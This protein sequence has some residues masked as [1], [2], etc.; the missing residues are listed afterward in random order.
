MAYLAWLLV[1]QRRYK[2]GLE[3]QIAQRTAEISAAQNQLKSTLDA[4][5]DP[6]FELGWMGVITN[7]VQRPTTCW[8]HLAGP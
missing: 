4:I 1:E 3:S 5:R 8:L 2:A 6:I 7:A